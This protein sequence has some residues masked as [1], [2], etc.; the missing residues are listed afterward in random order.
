[1]DPDGTAFEPD[2]QLSPLQTDMPFPGESNRRRTAPD[3]DTDGRE[4]QARNK[5]TGT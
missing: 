1:M 2:G 3:R 4:T 5:R